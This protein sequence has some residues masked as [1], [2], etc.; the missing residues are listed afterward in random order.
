VLTA[1]YEGKGNAYRQIQHFFDEASPYYVGRLKS[2][3]PVVAGHSYFTDHGDS[4]IVNVRKNLKD[5]CL[6]YKTAFW[7]S[8]YSML[9]DGY[10]EGKKGKIPAMDCALFLAKMIHFDFT[11]ANASAWQFWNA[12]EPGNPD[13]D[14]RYHLMVLK[15]NADN[16]VGDFTVTKNLWA[17]GHYSRFVR[18]GMKRIEISRNDSLNNIQSAQRIMLSAFAN[19]N[20][21][22]IVVLNYTGEEKNVA[23]DIP[24]IKRL[25]AVKQ[26]VT[27]AST[28]DNMKPYPLNSLTDIK[29]K[30]RSVTT[31]VIDK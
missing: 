29:L 26:Y 10:K 8:E 13:F 30:P 5:S 31:I 24:G 23:L 6:K 18:P 7:Q 1:L 9:G 16:S 21:V 28:E 25:K 15:T 22:V 27:S 3:L 2:V 12:W 4:V 11:E 20:Q 14:V 17:L 19:T